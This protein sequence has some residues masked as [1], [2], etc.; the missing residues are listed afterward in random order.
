MSAVS[1]VQLFVGKIT[2]AYQLRSQIGK[3]GLV[4]VRTM[5][6]KPLPWPLLSA[7]GKEL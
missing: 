6:S 5:A 7:Y 1:L 2:N 4:Y 3:R